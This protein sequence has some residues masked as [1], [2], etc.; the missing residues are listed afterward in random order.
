M[1]IG[2]ANHDFEKVPQLLVANA[3]ISMA[4]HG[5]GSPKI[6]QVNV[7]FKHLMSPLPDISDMFRLRIL[8]AIFAGTSLIN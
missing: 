5:R 4:S 7:S 8:L 1:K 2:A 6:S 3:M